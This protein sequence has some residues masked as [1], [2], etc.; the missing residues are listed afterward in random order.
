M[1]RSLPP[2]PSLDQLRRQAK[3]LLRRYA[4]GDQPT[5]QLF[6]QY[7]GAGLLA[8]TPRR[9]LLA[10]ALLII[11]REH[12]FASWP[13]LKQH[14]EGLYQ[15]AQRSAGQLDSRQQRQARKLARQQHIQ[16]LA[17]RLLSAARQQDLAA[18]FRGLMISA[19]DGLA[20]RQCLVE[21]G[22]YTLIIDLL[23]SGA[24][25][26]SA[27]MRF[28]SAQAMDHFADQRCAEPLQRLLGDP[29]PRV[30]WAALH[31]LQCEAC[32]LTPLAT[33]GDMLTTLIDMARSDP[34][35]KVRRVAAYELG[36]ICPDP[37]AIA[38]LE[39]ILAEASDPTI[40]RN[41]RRA[42]G[43]QAGP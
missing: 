20:V 31:S 7:L 12:G 26:P 9:A 34:S 43:R 39:Q 10:Q 22:H 33:G 6:A 5:Q 4:A 17:E 21:Q 3:E 11:A 38:A 35:V 24:A 2:R 30:R 23:L 29:V 32:K 8:A 42:L 41:A 19:R 40:V 1:S 25:H 14:V 37:Q 27:R 36:Q 15:V 28:L 18:L 16:A 13:K